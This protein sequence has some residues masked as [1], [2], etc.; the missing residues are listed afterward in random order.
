MSSS[1]PRSPI[2]APPRRRLR[3]LLGLLVAVVATAA[4]LPLAGGT[5]GLPAAS[6]ATCTAPTWSASAVYTAGNQVTYSGRTYRAKWWTQNEV[7][8]TT[9]Q[10]GVWED[11]G[12]CSGT[13]PTD[14]PTTTPPTTTPPT[15]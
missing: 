13:T 8:G 4:L 12:A 6:A 5:A 7:P 1:Q 11:Q 10:W 2:A 15:T 14:P 3:R 9:G